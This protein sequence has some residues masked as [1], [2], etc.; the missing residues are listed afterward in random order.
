MPRLTIRRKTR[1]NSGATSGEISSSCSTSGVRRVTLVTNLMISHELDKVENIIEVTRSRNLKDR[2]CNGQKKKGRRTNNDLQLKDRQCNGQKK[3]V[4]RT[5]N[6][7]QLKDP[8]LRTS[9]PPLPVR[10]SLPAP[11]T[12]ISSLVVPVRILSF[13]SPR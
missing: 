2:Q 4:R 8:A 5:N 9:I 11:A 12:K 7:L 13:L 10:I 6:D 3:K 1:V